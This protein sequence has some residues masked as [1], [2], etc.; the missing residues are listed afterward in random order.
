M[1]RR[2]VRVAEVG[3]ASLTVGFAAWVWTNAAPLLIRPVFLWAGSNP[4]VAAV[5]PLQTYGGWLALV[6]ALGAAGRVLLERRILTGYAANLSRV[7][8]AGL[9]QQSRT[10][11]PTLPGAVLGAAAMTL[12]LSGLIDNVLVGIAVLA[13]FIGLLLLRGRLQER[14]T[15]VLRVL[16][17]VP[18]AAR[19]AVGLVLAYVASS[20]VLGFFWV[21]TQTFLPVLVA[22][23]AGA[24]VITLLGIDEVRVKKAP[25][26]VP[27][28]GVA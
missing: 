6:L 2:V 18:R 23:C 15:A 21:R 11:L 10:A 4:T 3:A 28:E 7:L 22:A 17:R 1:S 20:A 13:F 12:R 9:I 16:V 5:A 25:S 14:P 27:A 8:H 24:A 19:L 26:E